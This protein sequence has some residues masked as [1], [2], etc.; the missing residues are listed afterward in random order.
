VP[1]SVAGHQ[2][3]ARRLVAAPAPHRGSRGRGRPEA[4]LQRSSSSSCRIARRS[5]TSFAAVSAS[6]VV[7][8]KRVRFAMA[9]S[10]SAR[11]SGLPLDCHATGSGG[12]ISGELGSPIG[13]VFSIFRESQASPSAWKSYARSVEV[14]SS[15][16]ACL[17]GSSRFPVGSLEPR[18]A[19]DMETLSFPDGSLWWRGK[20]EAWTRARSGV[21]TTAPA[22][23]LMLLRGAESSAPLHRP[24]R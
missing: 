14:S 18:G 7:P 4:A 1:R 19:L 9:R 10:S 16:R 22:G 15:L 6:S 5:V 8:S 11:R 20:A 24:D 21:A 17:V 2:R 23:I 3:A 12:A 13:L